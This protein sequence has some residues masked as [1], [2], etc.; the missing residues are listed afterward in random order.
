MIKPYKPAGWDK[1]PAHFKDPNGHWTAIDLYAA[2]FVINEKVMKQ[3]N[4]PIPQGWNDL[5]NPAYKDMLIMPNLASSGTGF[6]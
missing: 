2:A 3:K 1:I 6:L 4:L 5:L